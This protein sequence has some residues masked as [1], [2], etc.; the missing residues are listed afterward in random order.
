VRLINLRQQR[1]CCFKLGH[2][3][4]KASAIFRANFPRFKY[5]CDKWKIPD[6][7]KVCVWL[8]KLY[9][10]EIKNIANKRTRLYAD[11]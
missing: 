7:L 1:D 11:V 5:L 8:V 10:I 2:R 4:N 9:H 3:D 6:A